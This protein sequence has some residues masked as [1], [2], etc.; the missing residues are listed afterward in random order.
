MQFSQPSPNNISPEEVTPLTGRTIR[1]SKKKPKGPKEPEEPKIPIPYRVQHTI[2]TQT[3]EILEECFYD[4]ACTHM[5][6]V[7][8][9]RKWDCAA[10]AELTEWTGIFRSSK[11][12]LPCYLGR[13][14]LKTIDQM[15]HA[16]VHRV[17][18]PLGRILEF[19]ECGVLVAQRFNDRTRAGQI[20]KFHSDL[21]RHFRGKL[22]A[23]VQ[24]GSALETSA[25]ERMQWLRTPPEDDLDELESNIP[26]ELAHDQ[27]ENPRSAGALNESPAQSICN[28]GNI[29]DGE[30]AVSDGERAM[31]DPGQ[32]V[33][34]GERALSGHGQTVSDGERTVSGGEVTMEDET[35]GRGDE[36]AQGEEA[37]DVTMGE[38]DINNDVD[39]TMEEV[40]EP[41]ESSDAPL[42]SDVCENTLADA[43]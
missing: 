40:K 29:L 27:S 8:R 34:D 43:N 1:T 32:T 42:A 39:M 4:Y 25:S 41:E 9:G 26:Q 15:R 14:L 20:N 11:A 7:I 21:R 13:N 6:G 35:T 17:R 19:L 37:K 33:S 22:T 12:N 3:Q 18:T 2:L 36:T 16:A 38:P 10:A 5:G 24:N 31:S 28:T 30:H 23:E